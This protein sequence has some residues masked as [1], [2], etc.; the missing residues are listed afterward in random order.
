MPIMADDSYF[1]L[2]FIN[3]DNSKDLNGN[4]TGKNYFNINNFIYDKSV[5]D[6]YQ[7]H[8]QNLSF[9]YQKSLNQDSNLYIASN[10]YANDLSE[11]SS[12]YGLI[13]ND[14]SFGNLASFNNSNK[15]IL[16]LDQ[17][18]TRNFKVKTSFSQ[19]S[20]HYNPLNS[21]IVS[22]I[23]QAGLE[24]KSPFSNLYFDYGKMSEYQDQFLGGNAKGIFSNSNNSKTDFI[25][26]KNKKKI[27]KDLYFISSYSEGLTDLSG[28]KN[29]IFRNYSDIRSRGYS[30]GLFNDNFFGGRLAINYSEPLRV[31][32]GKVDIDIPISRDNDGN[33]SRLTANNISL[34]PSGQEKN[35]E[36]SYSL[37][38]KDQNLNLN[39]LA[40]EEPMN[41]KDNK[42]EYMIFLKYSK[43]W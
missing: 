2:K 32:F 43:F 35:L 13:N 4:I 6:P 15:N 23:F 22:D 21:N 27:I 17:K 16:A 40:I 20:D 7:S 18:M 38:E 36:I 1:S 11:L 8:N 3:Q 31:Y 10:D 29:G 28:N 30:M 12:N 5:I 9:I 26:I 25:T 19:I 14:I 34:E 42:D 33:I 37:F 41:V 24:Y 39:F